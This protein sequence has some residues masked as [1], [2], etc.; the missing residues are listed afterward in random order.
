MNLKTALSDRWMA[1]GGL[2]N[3]AIFILA[4]VGLMLS[5]IHI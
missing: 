2:R 5:L 3:K 1:L 4:A